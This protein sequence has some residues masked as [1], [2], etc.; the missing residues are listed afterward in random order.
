M[1]LGDIKVFTIVESGVSLN[2]EAVDIGGGKVQFLVKCVSGSTNL[3]ALYWDDGVDDKQMFDLGDKKD[4]SLNMNGTKHDW[5]GGI[6]LSPTGLGPLGTANPTYLT[7]G[8]HLE[9]FSAD[10]SFAALNT[11]GARATSTGLK[12]VSG[13]ATLIL[14]PELSVSDAAPVE[15]GKTA[16]FTVSLSHAYLHDIFVSYATVGGTATEDADY[17]AAT[18]GVWIKAGDTSV[19]IDVTTIDDDLEEGAI[20]ELFTLKLL[21]AKADLNDDSDV[22]DLVDLDI[23]SLVL[24]DSGTGSII[25][26]DQPSTP[27]QPVDGDN[28]PT[29]NGNVISATFYFDT[30]DVDDVPGTSG[31]KPHGGGNGQ[32]APA[33]DGIFA[34]Q[35][36]ITG[37]STDLN[38]YYQAILDEFVEQN[39]ITTDMEALLLG[40]AI[41]TSNSAP[42]QLFYAIDG[43]P[44]ADVW[45]I[46]GTSLDSIEI[47]ATA[48]PFHS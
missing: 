35:V 12:G 47:D 37:S 44:D 11:L 41:K 8:E 14:A 27:E 26:N 31:D 3:N 36:N 4:N 48:K 7:P 25:D 9:P 5:D 38:L 22:T 42:G 29:N 21:S 24:D 6:K 40:V 13:A 34:V 45:S 20:P 32:N 28:F 33:D 17:N 15:E 19:T 10:L 2:V 23:S 39:L 46:V 43:D 1:A 30:R 16:T 18:G